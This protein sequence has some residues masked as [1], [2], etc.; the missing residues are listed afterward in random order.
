MKTHDA[1]AHFGT[2]AKLGAAIGLKQHS[3]SVWGEFPPALRQLQIEHV[4][5]GALKASPGIMPKIKVHK[6]KINRLPDKDSCVGA[7]KQEAQ[8]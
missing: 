7:I 3:I 2:Q 8:A 1:I 6:G 5:R 4:T